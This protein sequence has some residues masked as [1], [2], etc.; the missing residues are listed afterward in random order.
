MHAKKTVAILQ[1][2]YIPWKGYFDL[3]NSVDEFILL[4]DVQYTRRDWRNRNII[5]TAHGLHWLTIPVINNDYHQKIKDTKI[6]DRKWA[7]KHWRTIQQFYSNAPFFSLYRQDF[8]ELYIGL[9]EENLSKINFAFIQKIN[10]L[11]GIKTRISW[12]E[13]YEPEEGKVNR[14]ISLVKQV[15]GTDY[16]SGPAAKSY[17][18]EQQLIDAGLNLHWAVYSGYPEYHQLYPP[19]HHQVSVLD[20]LFNEGPTAPKFMKS[21]SGNKLY[22]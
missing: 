14:L 19:F 15:G 18:D 22:A 16:L 21:F 7:E 5:K 2:N 4:D 17:I 8:E 1:S 12:S 13:D 9:K 11:L 6:S 10:K 20:L 3:I